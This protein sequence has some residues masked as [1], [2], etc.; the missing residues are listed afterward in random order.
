M[1]SGEEAVYK[2]EG[3]PWTPIK[4]EDNKDIIALLEAPNTGVYATLDGACK[5]PNA[6]G[7]TFCAQLHSTHAKSKVLAAPKLS[8]KKV[9]G[10]QV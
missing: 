9:R 5:T 2:E 4:Y 8:S 3:V 6:T 1:F 7:K 10:M